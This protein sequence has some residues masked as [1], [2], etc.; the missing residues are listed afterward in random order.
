MPSS[1]SLLRVGRKLIS[2]FDRFAQADVHDFAQGL[3]DALLT[4][5]EAGV[6]PERV[7]ENDYLMK[8]EYGLTSSSALLDSS[9]R[10]PS[11]TSSTSFFRFALFRLPMHDRLYF[12]LLSAAAM[13][14]ILTAKQ[15]LTPG[16]E[17]TLARLVGILGIV[18]KNP[19]NPNFD[20]YL[21]ESIASLLRYVLP[22]RFKV[23][24]SPGGQ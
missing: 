21:F 23:P 15:T 1:P 8:C 19:S 4:K 7:A 11:S 13:R 5:I 2:E 22:S 18:S 9:C 3:L 14:V 10:T 20:Q 17:R 16:Y 24:P 6:S 12:F